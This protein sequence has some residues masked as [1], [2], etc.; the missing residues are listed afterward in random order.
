MK[1]HHP[2]GMSRAF[3]SAFD[4]IKASHFQATYGPEFL[5]KA[6]GGPEVGAMRSYVQ[7][8]K[9]HPHPDVQESVEEVYNHLTA[10]VSGR[11]TPKPRMFDM[12]ELAEMREAKAGPMSTANPEGTVAPQAPTPMQK[13]FRALLDAHFLRKNVMGTQDG[14]QYSLP[15]SVA[16]MA[17]R[18]Q[19]PEMQG[20][21]F[22]RRPR[23]TGQTVLGG[24]TT[25]NVQPNAPNPMAGFGT[26]MDNAMSGGMGEMM[27]P[28]GAQI[29]RMPHPSPFHGSTLGPSFAR[30]GYRNVG[31]ELVPPTNPYKGTPGL[32][33]Y[34]F[35]NDWNTKMGQPVGDESSYAGEISSN[36]SQAQAGDQFNRQTRKF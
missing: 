33:A 18:P 23:P 19:V 21:G 20:G 15:P 1:R 3:D 31:G 12:H 10:L 2:S 17:Q 6:I 27:P 34:R 11:E 28:P 26:G 22:F 8:N 13:A 29:E 5:L 36:Q 4:I 24:P 30:Q 14:I 25:M 7:M 16:S 32:N 35:Y 9:Q